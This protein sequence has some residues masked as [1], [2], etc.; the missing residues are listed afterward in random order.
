MRV[1]ALGREGRGGAP[2]EAA[3]SDAPAHV[4]EGVWREERYVHAVERQVLRGV[5]P[6]IS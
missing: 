3:L 2:L 5:E 6:Y 1:G 4:A